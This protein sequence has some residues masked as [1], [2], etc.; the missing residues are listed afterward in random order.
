MLEAHVRGYC[1]VQRILSRGWQDED[2]L[3]C[4]HA[5]EVARRA[6]ERDRLSL[7]VG[8]YAYLLSHRSE[9]RTAARTGEEGL[10]LALDVGDAYHYMTCQ[11]HRAW[12]L[13]HLG[14]WGEMRRVL[15][16]GLQMAERNGHDLWARAFRVQTAWLFIYACDFERA[17]ALCQRE[18]EPGRPRQLGELGGS[19]VL[20]FAQLG[21]KRYAAALRAFEEVTGR[22]DGRSALMDWI[23]QMPLRLGLGEYWL[24]RR[25]WGRARAA[26]R[27]ALP[28][29]R[30]VRRAHLPGTRPSG[31]RRGRARRA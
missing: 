20:G 26:G 21:A 18:L 5:I 11:F 25:G 3:A 19:I 9:Y 17:L 16:D 7:H 22:T 28:A 1:G 4:R 6:G 10:E 27:G 8:H 12:A 30:D 23:L 2:A 31:A 13:L 29:R 15:Y 14:E 24:A